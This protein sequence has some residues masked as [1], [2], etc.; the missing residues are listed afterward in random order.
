VLFNMFSNS[1][2]PFTVACE[3]N[4]WQ[5]TE[6]LIADHELWQLCCQ[7]RREIMGLKNF[8]LAGKVF[9]LLMSDSQQAKMMRKSERDAAAMGYTEFN[10]FHHGGKVLQQD[11]QIIENCLASG[12]QD[13]RDMSATRTLLERW[14]ALQA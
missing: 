1:F 2:F 9:S 11:I 5:G 4:G 8:G 13:G 10:K 12:E 3:I 7:S 14:R 6:A